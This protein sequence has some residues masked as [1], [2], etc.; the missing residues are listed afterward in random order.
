MIR[1]RLSLQLFLVLLLASG[2]PLA[3]A[4]ALSLHQTR[5]QI[6]AQIERDHQRLA[7]SAST[8]ISSYLDNASG[9]IEAISKLLDRRGL[10]GDEALAQQLS[11]LLLPA[12]EF[13]GLRYEDNR[14]IAGGQLAAVAQGFEQQKRQIESQ[15][16]Q[17]SF[18]GQQAVAGPET[19]NF[20]NPILSA[21][22]EDLPPGETRLANSIDLFG[23]GALPLNRRV[24][25]DRVLSA[26]LRLD[27]LS[28]TLEELTRGSTRELVLIHPDQG[29]VLAASSPDLHAPDR[30]PDW[31]E[32]RHPAPEGWTLLVREPRALAYAPLD[33]AWA[34][35]KIW[36]AA[37]AGLAIALSLVFAAWILRPIRKLTAAAEQLQAGELSTRAGIERTDEIGQLARAFDDMAAAVESLDQVK[38]EF[39]S[40]V[41][42][43][44]R[45]PL[46]AMKVS[47]ENLIDGVGS[48]ETLP[49]LRQ[50]IDRLIR[51]VNELLELA[52]LDSG[53]TPLELGEHELSGL[54]ESCLLSLRPLLEAKELQVERAFTAGPT[55]CDESRVRQV[56]T[57]LLDNAIKAAPPG[58]TIEVLVAPGRIEVSDSGPGVPAE[59]AEEIF[60][61]FAA[62][63]GIGL[64][65]AQRIVRLHG[66]AISVAGSR[67]SA[68][69]AK[70]VT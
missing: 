7:A 59:R 37:G 65:I 61:P 21:V 5:V 64:S 52:R 2:L 40:T 43:E 42:H 54:A 39:V 69:L 66:G 9:K 23:N 49:R 26:D 31:L 34:R 58:G 60:K 45:T 3:G 48:E 57:N 16:V 27:P 47:V 19:L 30:H 17:G 63:G 18:Q 4:A 36:G 10:L 8:L 70:N 51:L 14:R 1:R 22:I 20:N 41:S 32:T 35:T 50:D 13:L 44:L 46:T 6:D 68:T 56:L 12:D 67:F 29:R 15:E 25:A 24:D 62:G 38:S 28:N 53:A 55:R 33:A 11:D